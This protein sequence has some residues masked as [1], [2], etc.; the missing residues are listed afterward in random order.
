MSIPLSNIIACIC[1]GAAEQ[2]IIELLLEDNLL[3]FTR[4]NLID[5]K[6]IRI[7]SAENFEKT[8]LTEKEKDMLKNLVNILKEE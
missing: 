5:E 7:R 4:E 2:T 8:Y 1:E 3:I 6:V